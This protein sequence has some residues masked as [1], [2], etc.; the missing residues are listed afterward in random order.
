MSRSS[1]K[2][3]G[4]EDVFSKR[5]REDLCVFS[6]DRGPEFARAIFR[7]DL[8]GVLFAVLVWVFWSGC[9]SWFEAAAVP[10]FERGFV[11]VLRT[12]DRVEER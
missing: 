11:G 5:R 12:L 6:T 2:G 8:E 4:I 3:L 7:E 10:D 9:S 1:V